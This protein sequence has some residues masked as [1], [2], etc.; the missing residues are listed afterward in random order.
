MISNSDLTVYHRV[1]DRE[2]R[3][4]TWQR[5]VYKGIWWFGGKGASINK[6]Y[7]NANDVEIR[8]S[9]DLNPDINDFSVGDIL[10]KGEI[11]TEITR[12]QDLNVK[13]VYN[14]TSI[15]DNTFGRRPHIHIGGK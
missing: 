9:Y 7:D 14:I 12:Q 10:V 15:K 11:E 2:Q 8:I 3:K 6:G 13:E 1:F 4:D 5:T